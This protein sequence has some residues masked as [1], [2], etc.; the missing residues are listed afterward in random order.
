MVGL[1][2]ATTASAPRAFA[3]IKMSQT[4][5]ETDLDT[6]VV[7]GNTHVA[8]QQ[9]TPTSTFT[10]KKVI[11]YPALRAQ[12]FVTNCS[13][14][15]VQVWNNS[16]GSAIATFFSSDASGV[17]GNVAPDR[18]GACYYSTSAS[19]SV[20]SGTT[21]NL[22][23]SNSVS[24][25]N[26]F[27]HA[28]T[29]TSP[30]SGNKICQSVSTGSFAPINC[31][32]VSGSV[33]QLTYVLSDS[34][35]DASPISV[36]TTNNVILDT[37]VH[38]STTGSTTVM[39]TGTYY[40]DSHTTFSA[41]SLTGVNLHLQRTDLMTAPT[42]SGLLPPTDI[43]IPL[44]TQ[45]SNVSWTTTYALPTGT[46]WTAVA[47]LVYGTTKLYHSNTNTF[48]VVSAPVV[49]TS[50]GDTVDVSG[51]C[52]SYG[53]GMNYLCDIIVW[54]FYPSNASI[55]QFSSLTLSHSA[56][57]SYIYD[58]PTLSGELFANT[59]STT[60]SISIPFMGST[61]VLLDNSM[62]AAVPFVSTVR[63]ILG[64]LLY[65]AT[66]WTLYHLLLRS[67]DKH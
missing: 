21:Y 39:F 51:H 53:F 12:S 13:A 2:F 66:A 8:Y 65:L 25:Q 61:L 42:S 64:Y 3:T 19:P 9:F 17:A 45:D 56:P 38:L 4:A 35:T 60:V 1:V 5:L 29:T 10:L 14:I 47:D 44:T 59:G 32:T 6:W 62:I 20:T 34:L 40:S 11:L 50:G 24:S 48:N 55:G 33:T 27:L 15:G 67:H 36:V 18:N 23:F 30:S 46:R 54:L 28:T 22:E 31:G 26:N 43:L 63:T 49:S 41:G 7:S 37:P 57:F 52:G 58:I 16:G